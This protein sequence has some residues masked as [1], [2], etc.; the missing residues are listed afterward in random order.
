M[1]EI[2]SIIEKRFMQRNFAGKRLVYIFRLVIVPS[3]VNGLLK[4]AIGFDFLSKF[5]FPSF[6]R[7]S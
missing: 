2:T 6:F 4:Y 5:N 3:L 1:L 7:F